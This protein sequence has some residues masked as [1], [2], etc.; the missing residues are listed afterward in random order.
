MTEVFSFKSV[1]LIFTTDNKD[2]VKLGLQNSRI[3]SRE[4]DTR[5]FGGKCKT[6]I[7]ELNKM[8]QRMQC[9]TRFIQEAFVWTNC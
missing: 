7:F 3:D 5:A 9:S 4:T 6:R 2:R 1:H 8:A